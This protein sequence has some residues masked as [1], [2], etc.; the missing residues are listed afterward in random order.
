[1]M[2]IYTTC[3]NEKE[4]EKIAAA[5]LRARL[6]GCTNWWPIRG[7][8]VWKGRAEKVREVALLLKTHER[9]F[10]AVEK[11][12]KKLHSYDV[13]CIVG[14]KIDKVNKN[15]GSWVKSSVK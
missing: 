7:F 11:I 1:M 4:V 13:P 12:I 2:F 6:G 8:Y 3:E 5:L 15:F 9:H 10:K 14:W